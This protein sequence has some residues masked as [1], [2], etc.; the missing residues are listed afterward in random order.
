MAYTSPIFGTS[1]S[2]AD[3][4]YGEVRKAFESDYRV[5]HGDRKFRLSSRGIVLQQMFPNGWV[6]LMTGHSDG[7]DRLR[8]LV[9]SKGTAGHVFR[10]VLRFEV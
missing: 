7:M 4:A 3:W 1:P 9:K 6:N 2:E 10:W 5:K 8:M